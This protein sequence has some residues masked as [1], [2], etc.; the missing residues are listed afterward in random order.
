MH[1]I[2]LH[3]TEPLLRKAVRVFVCRAVIRQLGVKFLFGLGVVIA[4]IAFLLARH[5]GG[6]VAGFMIAVVFFVGVFIAMV[7]VAHFR[8]TIGRFRE[9]RTPEVTFGYDEEELAFK[10]EL[11]AASMP[12]SAIAEV[13]KYEH[14][15]LLLFSRS[16][17]VT[18][19]LAD[20]EDGARAFIARKMARPVT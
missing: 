20:L 8:N 16:Q 13:W 3:Y 1:E 11:G 4:C 14:F 15:W 10:S 12:W 7:Y 5:N 17:F 9:M 19:P 2:T 6:G 18:L